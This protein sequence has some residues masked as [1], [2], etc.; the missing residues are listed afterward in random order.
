MNEIIFVTHNKGK[1]ATAKK[2]LQ[3]IDFKVFEYFW[4]PVKS[5]FS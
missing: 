3:E 2:Q 5:Y 4:I 1:I